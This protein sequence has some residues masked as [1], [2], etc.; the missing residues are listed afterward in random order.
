MGE[1]SSFCRW[2]EREKD[3]DPCGGCA[4]AVGLCGVSD[5]MLIHRVVGYAIA[6][7]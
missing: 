3:R 2:K 7:G 4:I 6:I 5:R 1:K